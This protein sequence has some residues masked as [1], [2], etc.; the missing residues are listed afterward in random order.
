MTSDTIRITDDATREQLTVAIGALKAKA[1]R[2]SRHDP[3]RGEIDDKV[4]ALV[5]RWLAASDA[6]AG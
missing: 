2:L 1:E 4:D 5:T 3:R 6:E